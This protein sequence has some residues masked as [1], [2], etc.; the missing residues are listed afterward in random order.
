MVKVDK[1]KLLVENSLDLICEVNK[2]GRFIFVNP[3]YKE[4]LGY[5]KDE[6]MGTLAANYIHPHDLEKALQKFKKLVNEFTT[7]TNE[8]RFKD[9]WGHWHWLEC[10][11]SSYLND[12]DE[13][14]VV[15]IS[16]DI[17]Q[18]KKN[19]QALVDNEKLF[20]ALFEQA[21]V[22]VTQIETQTGRF[23]KIN[24]KFCDIVGYSKDEMQAFNFQ[25][26]TH[27]DD[28]QEDLDNM[29]LLK[30]GKIKEFTMEKRYYKKDGSL[31]WV[32]LTV[33]PLWKPNENPFYHVAVIQ[34]ITDKKIAE[35][36]LLK[37]KKKSKK[38]LDIA[39]VMMVA[40][41]RNQEVT[42]MNQKGCEL[43]GYK[44]SEILGKNWFDF[45]LPEN[46]R[47]EVRSFF[48]EWV[49]GKAEIS[50]YFENT[51]LHKNG[52]ERIIAWHNTEI[53]DDFGNPIETLS[54]GEDIT[55]KK[56]IE[57]AL[58]KNEQRFRTTVENLPAGTVYRNKNL[59]F[60]NKAVE[61][62]T[63]YSKKK[64]SD[65]DNWFKTLYKDKGKEIKKRYEEEVK[66]KFPNTAIT[67]IKTKNNQN[68]WIQISASFVDENKD[69]WVIHDIT[70][71]K[72]AEEALNKSLNEKDILLKE[73]NHRVKN[74]LQIVSGLLSLQSNKIKDTC[75]LH[76]F[77]DAINRIYAM[78][79]IH[80]L[81]YKVD[82]ISN[83]NFSKYIEDLSNYIYHS[84]NIDSHK[85]I[86]HK[87][88]ANV[89]LN[90]NKAISCGL[91][92]NE[93]LTNSLK[94]AFPGYKK[95][96]IEISFKIDNNKCILKI[97]DDGIGIL[98][99][100]IKNLETLGLQLI[101]SLTEQLNGIIKINNKKGTQISIIFPK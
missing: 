20:R 50:E 24:Q 77:K 73:I 21:A 44:E 55:E 70:D 76:L 100:D 39:G 66:M 75:V 90:M 40:I 5:E 64:L 29:D 56:K 6:L 16:R 57:Q 35:D 79:L 41:N 46:K 49:N 89:K 72:L 14:S 28:L 83:I 15:V 88:L 63:G 12:Q 74:N 27:P 60:V 17:T 81:L 32:S 59:L 54:S 31:V 10:N 62:I 61:K 80:E 91:I 71:K 33:S 26:I 19:E 18:K 85:I 22:G 45:F 30:Q 82:D 11:G 69:I 86:L 78:S 51:I 4:K 92:I 3:Q 1:Y 53:I 94:Y 23:I 101:H 36:L 34:D 96:N 48:M 47:E 95:G 58:I 68:K 25:T 37:E 52:E 93:L 67:K 97:S 7:S 87:N 42:L 98:K 84:M 65:L 43:L 38:Y 8:W 99:T 9:K 2:D 13:I